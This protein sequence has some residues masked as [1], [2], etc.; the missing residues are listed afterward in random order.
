MFAVTLFNISNCLNETVQPLINDDIFA[1][2]DDAC[3]DGAY[4]ARMSLRP[5]CVKP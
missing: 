3:Y 1:A 4:S 2:V 5:R